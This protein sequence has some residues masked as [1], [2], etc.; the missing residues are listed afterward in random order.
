MKNS[1]KMPDPKKLSKELG[2]KIRNERNE[3][4]KLRVHG[5][6]DP[7]WSDGVNMNL[8]RNHVI[9]LRKRIENELDPGD[10]PEEY[11]SELPDEMDVNYMANPNGIRKKATVVL[12]TL[13]ENADFVYLSGK[14][15]GDPNKETR[16]CMNVVR[17]ILGL[18]ESVR[19]DDLI[20][21]R[22]CQSLEYYVKYLRDSRKK[23][24]EILDLEVLE[25]K[26]H[27]G[28]L[29]IWDYIGG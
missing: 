27:E 6:Q 17:Y 5:G 12:K 28:Q 14:Y 19:N 3:Y 1:T 26:L 20:E 25:P 22:R 4:E 21:M 11:F 24:D 16:Q 2:A 18:E 9:Y 13:K 10:Y 23:L 7:F 8:C 29:T 15:S